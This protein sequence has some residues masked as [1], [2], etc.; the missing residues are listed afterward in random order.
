MVLGTG[1]RAGDAPEAAG[2]HHAPYL[3]EGLGF[4]IQGSGFGV[5][6]VGF[7]I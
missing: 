1:L 5:Q 3:L 7:R 2:H 4:S 6:G